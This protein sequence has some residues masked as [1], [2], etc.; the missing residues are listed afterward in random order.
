MNNLRGVYTIWYRDI[1]RSWHD[2]MRLIGA[3]SL[4]LLFLVVFGSGLSARMGFLAPGVAGAYSVRQ[5]HF[6]YIFALGC[7][8]GPRQ[9]HYHMINRTQVISTSS[10]ASA[11]ASKS[12]NH[13]RTPSSVNCDEGRARSQILPG[14]R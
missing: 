13:C 10:A 14:C 6:A 5:C 2:K 9:E 3:I 7:G 1:L 4:P 12:P 8:R 11:N